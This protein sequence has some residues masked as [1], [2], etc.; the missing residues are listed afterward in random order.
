MYGKSNM[1]IYKIINGN[2]LQYSCL[3]SPMDQG[4]WWATGHGVAKSQTRLLISF[5]S[6]FYEGMDLNGETLEVARF[7]WKSLR[8]GLPIPLHSFHLNFF[9]VV[10]LPCEQ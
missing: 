3:E 10:F 6:S 1:E 8:W 9:C 7:S 5:Y 4:A 2:P